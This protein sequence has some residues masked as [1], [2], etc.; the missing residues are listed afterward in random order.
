MLL[1]KLSGQLD[2]NPNGLALL[3]AMQIVQDAAE[4][5]MWRGQERDV[6]ERDPRF[7][8]HRCAFNRGMVSGIATSSGW[9][10]SRPEALGAVEL[11]RFEEFAAFLG[12]PTECHA[13][14]N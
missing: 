5:P 13:R 2:S 9:C 1:Q 11:M 10:H 6:V 12:Q 7:I 4:M 14:P 8:A 3:V